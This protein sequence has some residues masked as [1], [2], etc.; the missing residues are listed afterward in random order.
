MESVHLVWVAVPSVWTFRS[1]SWMRFSCS[2]LLRVKYSATVFYSLCG[3]FRQLHETDFLSTC[4]CV[5]RRL[6]VPTS[7]SRDPSPVGT[8]DRCVPSVSGVGSQLGEV[9]S[10]PQSE[11]RASQASPSF[12]LIFFF[13][14]FST[15]EVYTGSLPTGFTPRSTSICQ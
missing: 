2:A 11:F 3:G 5:S 15:G 10:D 8:R 6:A 14:A 12:R 1:I 4:A 13:A 7:R 9:F